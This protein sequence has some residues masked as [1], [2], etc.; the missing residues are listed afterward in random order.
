MDVLAQGPAV[1][2]RLPRFVARDRDHKIV[3]ESSLHNRSAVLLF[4]SPG[5][6]PC[7]EL[8]AELTSRGLAGLASELVVIVNSQGDMGLGGAVGLSVL[9]E[10]QGE[11]S[12]AFGISGRPFAVAVD[13]SGFIR[14]SR[15]VNKISEL[16]DL[17]L[18]AGDDPQRPAHHPNGQGVI[19]GHATSQ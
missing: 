10:P 17:M 2:A 9:A 7:K 8:A 3:D 5:C 19:S 11:V 1:G 4:L 6:G 15:F 13:Q 12:A 16:H 14:G 18:L